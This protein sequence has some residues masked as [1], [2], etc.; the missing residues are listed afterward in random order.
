MTVRGGSAAM[1]R[2]V[3]EAPA[4]AA[5]VGPRQAEPDRAEGSW[6]AWIGLLP[7]VITAVV[8]AIGVTTP[9][10]WRDEAATIAAVHR[11]ASDLLR[12][13][14][15]VDAVHGTYYWLVWPLARVFGTG[16]LV[17]RLP[18]LVAM[19]VSAGVVTATGRRLAS[20]A[21]GLIAGLVF[22]AAPSVTEFGQMA[23]S[24]ALVT[25][26]AA[27]A[28]YALVRALE[29]AGR[30][31]RWIWYAASLAVLG[32]LNIAALLLI[33]AHGITVGL[34]RRQPAAA[35]P[36]PGRSWLIAA[37][38][39][40]AV[41]VP[42][43]LLAFGQRSQV[44]WLPPPSVSDL[45]N[46]LD[47]LG[48]PLMTVAIAVIGLAAVA[49]AV[50]CRRRGG[51]RPD[52]P[53][54]RPGSGALA[55]LC[56]PWLAVPPA[57]LLLLSALI[58]P[59]YNQRYILFCMPGAALM[60]AVAVAAL[61]RM[62]GPRRLARLAPALALAA[63]LALGVS[64]QAQY[65]QPAGHADD[66]RAADAII[67]ARARPGDVMMYTWPVFMPISAAYRYGLARLPDIQVGQAAIPSGTLAGT[68]VPRTVVRGR[69][70]RARRLWIVQVSVLTPEA[71][72]LTGMHMRLASTWQTS[73]IWLQLYVPDPGRADRPG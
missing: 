21:V 68:T 63:L 19:A 35:G 7:A 16:E 41:N 9:S 32:A 3:A 72:L 29:D 31:R 20:P 26:G 15:N 51:A 45:G 66:V 5:S 71:R 44:R 14:G 56:V 23:R 42:L 65:R 8:I 70:S 25:M 46:A 30:R 40:F 64:M 6:Q 58:T 55:A 57:A 27:I 4:G 37:L 11:P 62:P 13:L 53:P 39:G 60:T 34:R 10:Y 69:I 2:T 18:S 1:A 17:M 49:V 22:A 73:D 54:E 67:A 61:A 59:L 48:P 50:A 47:Q 52:G 38:A 33:P 12:M 43:I 36:R 28:S 24:Y